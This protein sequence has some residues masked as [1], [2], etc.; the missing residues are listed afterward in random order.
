M[1]AAIWS[2]P[3][4]EM[5]R[6]PAQPYLHFLEN[7]GLLRLTNRPQWKFVKGGP[8]LCRSNAQP[9]ENAQSECGACRYTPMRR[10]CYVSHARG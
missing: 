5:H 1:G 10:W 3:I 4:E 6:F 2:S 7:H 9:F 8:Q